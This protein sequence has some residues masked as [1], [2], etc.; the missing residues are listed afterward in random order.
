[1]RNE[2]KFYRML[3][4]SHKS[5]E[6]EIIKTIGPKVAKACEDIFFDIHI[7]ELYRLRISNG[8]K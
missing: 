8:I 1:M 2:E 4:G 7:I 3:D 6:K 5:S